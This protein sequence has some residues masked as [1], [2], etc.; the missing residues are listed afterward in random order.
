MFRRILYTSQIRFA[1][2]SKGSRG[3]AGGLVFSPNV[4]DCYAAGTRFEF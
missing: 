3:L 2:E 4:I 1:R